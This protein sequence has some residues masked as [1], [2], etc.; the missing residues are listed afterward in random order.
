[1]YRDVSQWFTLLALCEPVVYNV[2][3]CSRLDVAVRFAHLFVEIFQV[4][5]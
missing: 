3:Y 2:C 4:L 1:M 5:S